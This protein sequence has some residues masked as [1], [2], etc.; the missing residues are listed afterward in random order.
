M[1]ACMYISGYA[2]DLFFWLADILNEK[3]KMYTSLS[4]TGSDVKMVRS[5]I[6]IWE[7]VASQIV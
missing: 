5:L 3:H 4:Q 6:P 1:Y 7:V 2:G